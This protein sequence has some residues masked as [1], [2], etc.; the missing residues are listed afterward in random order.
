LLE[1]YLIVSV[2]I[3]LVLILEGYILYQD[4]GRFVN[5]M[6]FLTSTIEFIW[7]L[8]SFGAIFT[9]EFPSWFAFIPF[10][11]IAYNLTSLVYDVV[12][13]RQFEDISRLDE[14]SIS[15]TWIQFSLIFS[16]AFF[17][18]TLSSVSSFL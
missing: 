10:Y 5:K 11:Y 16:V 13:A 7:L 6:L 14:M 9:I 15:K 4:S 17:G 3:G 12:L 8:V 2:I 1:L 18:L